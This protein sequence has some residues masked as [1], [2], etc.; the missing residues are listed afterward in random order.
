ML[1]ETIQ[2]IHQDHDALNDLFKSMPRCLAGA[3]DDSV[4]DADG[5]GKVTACSR[6]VRSWLNLLF[7]FSQDHFAREHSVMTG[8]TVSTDHANRHNEEHREM[9]AAIEAVARDYY[10]DRDLRAAMSALHAIADRIREHSSS[11]DAELIAFLQA[12]R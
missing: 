5:C 12:L 11:T 3:V 6:A 1:N 8:G 9:L 4:C 10:A 7:V 2:R